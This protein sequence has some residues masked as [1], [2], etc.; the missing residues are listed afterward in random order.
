[1]YVKTCLHKCKNLFDSSKERLDTKI[2]NY[3]FSKLQDKKPF[4]GP[5]LLPKNVNLT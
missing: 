3:H 2:L 5:F 1:M 4:I